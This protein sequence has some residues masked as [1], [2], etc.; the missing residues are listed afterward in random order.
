M[1]ALVLRESVSR[2]ME[3]ILETMMMDERENDE[4]N[5]MGCRELGMGGAH[6]TL[7][8]PHTLPASAQGCPVILTKEAAGLH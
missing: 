8:W 7:P 1:K 4:K 5:M 3:T 2:V 6:L